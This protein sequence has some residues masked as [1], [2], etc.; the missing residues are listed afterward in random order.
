[1]MTSRTILCLLVLLIAAPAKAD[2]A[3]SMFDAFDRYCAQTQGDT[4][5]VRAAVEKDG[6]VA[7][8]V[9]AYKGIAATLWIMPGTFAGSDRPMGVTAGRS[10]PPHAVTICEI[11]S[12]RDQID[13]IALF[14]QWA[15]VPDQYAN[16]P[17]TAGEHT[18]QYMFVWPGTQHTAL[19]DEESKN[20]KDF[21]VLTVGERQGHGSFAMLMHMLDGPP[22]E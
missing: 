19:S 9:P 16:E 1:M 6:A 11:H 10:E 12:P 7:H 13:G 15:G 4:E 2:P 17:A 21:W 18:E 14:G 3:A 20:T 8:E 22:P 5:A